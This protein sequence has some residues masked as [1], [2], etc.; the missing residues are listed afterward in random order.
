MDYKNQ[1]KIIDYFIYKIQIMN[2]VELGSYLGEDD[3]VR[4]EDLCGGKN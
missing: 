1:I 3:I 4:Y 2:E